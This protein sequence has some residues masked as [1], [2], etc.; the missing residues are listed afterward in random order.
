MKIRINNQTAKSNDKLHTSFWDN[1]TFKEEIR[2][3]LLEIA[4]R[5]I[6]DLKM[7]SLSVDDITLTGSLANYNWNDK[8]DIDLHL[9]VDFSDSKISDELLKDFLNLKRMMWNRLHDIK[10]KGHD[11]EIYIQD[12]DEPH[13]ST[14]VYSISNGEWIKKPEREDVTLDM[15]SAEAKASEIAK[16]IDSLQRFEAEKRYQMSS[17]LKDKIKKMR[18]TGLEKDGVYSVENL[19]FKILRREGDMQKLID[20]HNNAYDEMYSLDEKKK[21]KQQKGKKRA[22]KVAKRK[23]KK[24]KDDRCTRIAKRKYDVWPSAYASGAVVKCRQGKIWK[25][26]K[27]NLQEQKERAVGIHPGGFKPPHAGHFYGAKHLLDSGANEVLV[28]VSPKPRMGMSSDNSKQTEVTINEALDLWNLYIEANNLSDKMKVIQAEVSPVTTTYE[29]LKTLKPGTTVLLGK[30]DKDKGEKRFDRAQAFSDKND[31]NL[32]IEMVDTPMFGEGISGTRMREIIANDDFQSFVKYIP[33]KDSADQRRAWQIATRNT[34]ETL[35]ES[36]IN[37]AHRALSYLVSEKKK[38][39]KAKTDY[40]KEKKSGLHGWFSR[41]G[42]KGKSKGWV[43]CNTC[44]KDKKTG[45]KKCKPCGRKKGEKRSKYP[46]CRPTPASC[47][48]RGKGKKWG[49]KSGK[50]NESAN[51]IYQM[52]IDQELKPG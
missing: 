7:P 37:I 22:A 6:E 15:K 45:R 39:R 38:K 49:K 29:Y 46:A 44:R 18:Q 11:V 10:V 28:V 27:E 8:S 3:R 43:D 14:G 9:I 40:S 21:K 48:T 16:D 17:S 5:F 31:L 33:L 1:E 26:V 51:R 47:G 34:E 42:G 35:T 23:S 32:R 4:N 41:Q 50:T 2:Q 20:I 36:E 13:Y 30:G 24:K 25:G 19:A 12:K 52:F